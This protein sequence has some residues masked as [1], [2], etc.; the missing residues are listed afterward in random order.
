MFVWWIRALHKHADRESFDELRN[1]RA[2]G[3]APADE[4]TRKNERMN[5]EREPEI[6]FDAPY[7]LKGKI[8]DRLGYF[9]RCCSRTDPQI[10][11]LMKEGIKDGM[12]N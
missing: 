3:V 1:G 8:V 12:R 5:E 11:M 2:S 7:A 10:A 6:A 4:K 9:V